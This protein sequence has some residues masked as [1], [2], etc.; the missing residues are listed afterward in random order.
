MEFRKKRKRYFNSFFARITLHLIV[1]LLGAGCV[2]QALVGSSWNP[3]IVF[4]V[5]VLALE[6]GY[7]FDLVYGWPMK[8]HQ[9]E[10][11]STED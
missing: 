6:G 2:Y 8:E 7:W 11:K 4:L 10:R 1:M 9:G 3:V 5:V